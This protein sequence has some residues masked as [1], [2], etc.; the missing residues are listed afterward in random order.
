MTIE[1]LNQISSALQNKFN[2][3]YNVK[4]ISDNQLL[5]YYETLDN[6]TREI[7]IDVDDLLNNTPVFQDNPIKPEIMP[8]DIIWDGISRVR[9]W[10]GG[11]KERIYFNVI[12]VSESLHKRGKIF[13]ELVLGSWTPNMKYALMSNF[14]N[15]LNELELFDAEKVQDL[16]QSW[17]EQF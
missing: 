5:V 4:I 11:G 10:Y 17:T 3:Q 2:K 6:I 15:Q 16:Y 14:A 7:E 9:A 12:G 8:N 13:L 1:K